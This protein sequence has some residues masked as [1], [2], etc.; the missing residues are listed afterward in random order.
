MQVKN[1][2][3][4][5]MKMDK[6]LKIAC[7]G[8]MFFSLSIPAFSQNRENSDNAMMEKLVIDPNLRYGR[9]ENGLAYYIR[10]NEKPKGRAEF[11]LVQNVGSMQEE[12]HQ[13]GL[14]HF[15][16]HMSM[17][18]S[19]NFPAKNGIQD[20]IEK[21]GL[22]IGDN[23]NAY[24]GFDETVYMLMNVP[25]ARQGI[26]DSCL[27]ILHDWAAFL[28]LDDEAIEKERGV[29][30]EEWRTTRTAQM[31]LW[32]QQLPVMFPRSRYGKR[33]PIGILGIIENFPNKELADYYKRWYR[34]DLQAIIVIGD[35][36]V[37][38]TEAK[39]KSMF[40][41]IPKPANPEVKDLYIVQ[42][43]NIP[44]VSIAKDKEMTNTVLSLYFK[45]DKLPFSMKGTIADFMT[46]Y[47]L[48]VI[49]IIMRERFA[50]ILQRPNPPFVAA[51]A[52]DGDYSVAKT[53]GAWNTTAV[54][55]PNELK[56][57]MRALVAETK[58]V[59]QFGFTESEY[60]RAKEII[61]KEYESAYNERNNQENVAY[62]QEYIGHF[63]NLDYIPGIEIEYELIKQV[64]SLMPLEGINSFVNQILSEFAANKNIVISLV[65]PDM[66]DLVYPTEQ[67]LVT[68][69]MEACMERI[70]ENEEDEISKVLIPELPTPGKIIAETEEPL[71]GV[72]QYT[73][74]NGVRVIVKPTPFKQD[75]IVMN[76][77]SPG[78]STLFKDERDI[79]NLKLVNR[80]ILLGGL[81]EFSASDFRKAL[82]GKKVVCTT[83][84]TPSSEMIAGS[85]TPSDLKTLL[86][87][88][89]LQFTG[90]RKDE[91]AYA[92]FKERSIAELANSDL[93]PDNMFSDTLKSLAY[94]NSIRDMRLKAED[95]H[96]TDYNR[97]IEMYRERF[98]DASDFIF[99]FVGNIDKDTIRPLLEQYIATLPAI[100]RK[101]EPDETQITKI[102]RGK[103]KKHFSRPLET[104]KSTIGLMYSGEMP[105]NLKNIAITQVLNGIFDMLFYDKVRADESAS[106]QVWAEVDV[107]DFPKGRSSIQIYFDTDPLLQDKMIEVVKSELSKIADEGPSAN[108]LAKS[109]EMSLVKR[110]EM[111]Q[112][113]DYWLNIISTYYYRNLDAHHTYEEILNSITTDDIRLFTKE[114]LKQGNEIEVVMY[115][116]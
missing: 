110:Q 79:W 103:V 62:A 10:H 4:E 42:D 46:N 107:L 84:L 78:G 68:M 111:V 31:R 19:K 116:E 83:G 24:T 108:Y 70:V 94:D 72:T 53:K 93:D 96:K 45:H 97:M 106:Y 73:L 48:A 15:L 52:R 65:G 114:L 56:T 1:L 58:R 95:M 39:I 61:V 57:A 92:T 64:A 66:D 105:Y 34:P 80:A 55:K 27:L 59:V 88:I 75:E 22:K 104:P 7:L 29:I 90:I 82:A 85:A 77:I 35:L 37:D 9:L 8:I 98:A 109:I 40:S 112:E 20:Y 115:P 32:E 25:I 113:N 30:R 67:E 2:I 76:A 3:L 63:T 21:I 69:Y 71:F 11:Y 44:L 14:A 74:S 6:T 50:D 33:L 101:D 51:M 28:S 5:C 41:D 60:E 47:S 13:R 16:E 43:N 12:D 17:N 89:Y 87:I 102:H 91:E 36:D 18:G 86:E 81:G 99:T 38:K 26:I 49:S 23:M 100:N 54:V